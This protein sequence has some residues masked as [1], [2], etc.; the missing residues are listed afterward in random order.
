MEQNEGNTRSFRF[1]TRQQ[2]RIYKRLSLVG[3]GPA[4]FYHDACRI[5]VAEP[6]FETTTHLMGHCLRE[7]ESALRDVLKPAVGN[8]DSLK[9]KNMTAEERY[10][11]DIITILH[12]L[13]IPE[14]DEI[15]QLWLRLPGRESPF[16]LHRYAHRDNLTRP[17]PF[18]QHFQTFWREMETVFD[19]IR[20][21]FEARYLSAHRL[22]DDLLTTDAPTAANMETLKK[23]IPSNRVTLGYL[24]EKLSKSKNTDWLQPL[25]TEGFFKYPPQ[26]EY[27]AEK[28][29]VSLSPWPASRYLSHIAALA[30]QQV[31]EIALEIPDTEEVG[32]VENIYVYGDL[33]DTAL[34]LPSQVAVQLL[35][36]VRRWMTLSYQGFLAEKHVAFMSHL[37]YGD[38]ID[39]ALELAE[40]LLAQL[41]HTQTSFEL[42]HYREPLK[43]QL[44]ALVA[45]AGIRALRLFCDSLTLGIQPADEQDTSLPDS[46]TWRPA[47]EEH[48][49]NAPQG[50]ESARD[51]LVSLIRDAAEQIVR[52]E[53]G[54]LKEVISELEQHGRSIFHRC[55]LYLLSAFPQDAPE[56]VA[57][58]LTD[59]QQFDNTDIHHEY[60]LLAQAGFDYLSSND[61]AKILAWVEQ[62]PLDVEAVKASYERQ[63]GKPLTDE[64]IMGYIKGWQRDWLARLG[65]DLP[66]EWKDKYERLV[67]EMGPA[68]HP[69]FE[70]Y[71]SEV[72][73]EQ[74]SSPK[75]T[76]EL[77]TMPI[78]ELASFLR[79]WQPSP[80]QGIEDTSPTPRGLR[81][82][83]ITA[84]ETMPQRFAG[85]AWLFRGLDPFYVH[86]VLAGLEHAAKQQ[87]VFPWRSVITLCDWVIHQRRK[88]SRRK[89]RRPHYSPQWIEATKTVLS[90]L[91]VSL[92]QTPVEIPLE[93]RP[94]LWKVLQPL[95]ED[96]NPTR[97]DEQPFS[98]SPHEL[99]GF[100]FNT[101]RGMAM[102]AGVRY[103]L[104]V[105]R[106]IVQGNG[107]NEQ[108][109]G[110]F[111]ALAEVQEVLDHHLD[112][113]HDPSLAIRS[114]YG[115]WFPWLALLDQQWILQNI[116]RIF[117]PGESFRDWRN[118]AWEA[119][120]IYCP[121]S[122]NALHL[123][124]AEYQRAI[125]RVGESS[126]H[127]RPYPYDPD[128]HLAEHLMTFYWW[129]RLDVDEP[130]GLLVQFFMQAP[131]GLRRYSF[132]Y[133][134]RSLSTTEETISLAVLARLQ[135]LWEWFIEHVSKSAV[136]E[137]PIPEVAA[138]GWWFSSGQFDDSWAIM[139]LE[140]VLRLYE[141][142][143]M[144]DK[145]VERLAQLSTKMPLQTVT[146]I[147]LIAL[148]E[149]DSWVTGDW[150][151]QVR[152]L[153]INALQSANRDAYRKVSEVIN[154]LASREIADFRDLL[155]THSP[156]ENS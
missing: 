97:E 63:T 148:A 143:D 85:Q 36:R 131:E 38:Q 13:E 34:K 70:I 17:R 138:F 114:I 116:P 126:T 134:G 65:P 95:T 106:R 127:V 121:P 90:L 149:R 71:V 109:P 6:P 19:S 99:V 111:D 39:A 91:S 84:V 133:I 117:P 140:R 25:R 21:K 61:Q 87:R 118:A 66:P 108:A 53:I 64:L 120:V 93:L 77:S 88:P 40:A 147:Y 60:T 156:E 98:S 94:R 47:I 11:D 30:P 119:Y 141:K 51:L 41:F 107:G 79:N 152:I 96:P 81:D 151:K 124:L 27:D 137:T 20:E 80:S 103:A 62:G 102:H 100:T 125:W 49:Q 150:K 132:E 55:T 48:H 5:M 4:A 46:S 68:L 113:V 123:L 89:D 42:W 23:A 24:F 136:H 32:G 153:L 56:F 83:L 26:P 59:R 50:F 58:Y 69:E 75:S 37:A 105:Q 145:V 12:G 29:Q 129:G 110:G 7:I 33:L 28:K 67:T 15:A 44:P 142:I 2:K 82:R 45:R 10:K 155:E 130:E 35:P 1:L 54:S 154:L 92:E 18:D 112:L 78:K 128:E 73:W 135:R 115:L 9:K 57:R 3:E 122:V 72:T 22:I 16:G 101:I 43:T 14:T 139:Q 31:M 104:W 86:A 8:S 52:E 74:P 146:C 144:P 76:E